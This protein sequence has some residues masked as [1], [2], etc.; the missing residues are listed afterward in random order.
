MF[1]RIRFNTL[2]EARNEVVDLNAEFE[3]ANKAIETFQPAM[4]FSTSEEESSEDKVDED[5]DI[6]CRPSSWGLL[7][8]LSQAADFLKL[9][10]HLPKLVLLA[11]KMLPLVID[12]CLALMFSL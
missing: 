10:I 8:D 5:D 4:R 7:G 6:E 11:P 1:L 9:L 12:H 3:K 2:N